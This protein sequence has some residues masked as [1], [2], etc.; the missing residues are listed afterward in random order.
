MTEPWAEALDIVVARTKHERYRALCADS[1]PD[2]EAWRAK[3][4]EMAGKPK[5]PPLREQAANLAA[6]FWS[7]ATDGFKFAGEAEYRRRLDICLPCHQY[8]ADQGRC[9]LCGCFTEAK[10]RLRKEVCP[11][12]R[13]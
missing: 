1:H 13:W 4:I 12:G 3:M 7:W 5:Y 10:L 9:R 8:D 6:S 2:H 11:E